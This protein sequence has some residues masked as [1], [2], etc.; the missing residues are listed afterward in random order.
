MRKL[1]AITQ[2]TVDGVMQAPGGPEEDPSNGFTHGGWAMSSGDD[3]LSR[4]IGEI[5]AGDFDMLLGRRTYEIFS[6]YWPH[7]GD[8]PIA[9]AFNRAGKYVVTR[10]MR[11]LS[12]EHSV[13]IGGDV[14]AEL[15]KLKATE[16]P[17]LH[18]WG[19]SELL[20]TL[21]G[22]DLVDE[23]RLWVFPVVLGQ[24]KRLFEHNIPPRRLSLVAMQS[25][26]SGIL[27]NTYR[28]AGS[29]SA[30]APQA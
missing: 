11:P 16:G 18:I 1:I 28:P 4:V 10:S 7:A 15:V 17:E 8:N 24:G 19:S 27:L 14:V 23:F 5:M 3:V 2:V 30:K 12:W 25:T 26:P 21:I 9:N 6:G 20:Q 29:L 13:R 22:A